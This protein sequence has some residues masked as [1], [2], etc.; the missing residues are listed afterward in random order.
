MSRPT[1]PP[2]ERILQ[3]LQAVADERA[4]RQA[5]PALGAAVR[6][7]KAYQQRRFAHTYRDLLADP[8][9]APAARYFLDELYGP[10]DFTRRDDQFARIVPA[11]TRLFPEDIVATVATLAELHALSERLDS[12]MARQW[13]AGDASAGAVLDPPTYQRAWQACGEPEARERQIALTLQV[14]ETLDRLTRKRLLRQSLRMMRGPAAAAGLSDLQRFLEAGFD[15]FR[16]MNGA[17]DFLREVG[18]RERRLARSL[19]DA[20]A[21]PPDALP[22]ADGRG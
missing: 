9:Y 12:Q 16:A 17:E 22:A 7:L 21:L 19:F 15:T 1:L 8:R 11:M 18:A 6:A 3:W 2:G 10:S 5:E 20:S 13:L 4:R 14:G